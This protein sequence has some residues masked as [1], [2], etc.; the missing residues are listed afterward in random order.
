[1][2]RR[3]HENTPD[4]TWDADLATSAEGYAQKLLSDNQK[5]GGST[6]LM[7]HSPAAGHDYGE[8]I[9][10]GNAGGLN[11]RTIANAMYFW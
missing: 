10:I 4:L 2:A 6:Y 1:M 5:S 9:Y 7:D 8:N 3:Q 11:E